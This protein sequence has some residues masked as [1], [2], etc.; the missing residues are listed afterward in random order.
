MLE[1]KNCLAIFRAV[2]IRFQKIGLAVAFSPTAE[3]M[4]AEATRLAKLFSAE[5]MLIHVGD[6]SSKAERKVSAMAEAVRLTDYKVIWRNG[7]PEKEILEA[8]REK[9]IDLL[10]AGALKKENMIQRFI[11]SVARGIMRKADC[12]IFIVSEPSVEPKPIEQ[13]VVNAEDSAHVE[14]AIAVSCYL[15]E[16]ENSSWVHIVREIKMMGL[17]LSANEQLTAQEYS[18]SK[19]AMVRDEIIAV[20]K[21]LEKIPHSKTKVNIKMLSG[22]SGFELRRFVERKQADL[23]VVGAPPRRLSFFDRI[24]PHDLE[25][26]FA[27][28]PCNLLI[29]NKRKELHG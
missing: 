23:L 10:M 15:A 25:Y 2:N 28:M 18:E 29:I 16:K 17:T 13:I 22:K 8:C 3:A 20:E 6:R 14:S 26:I 21:I 27:D 24:F 1:N 12:S 9:N 19:Q 7:N 5:L 4:L 11:G